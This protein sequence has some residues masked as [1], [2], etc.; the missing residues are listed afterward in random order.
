MN[1]STTKGAK[2]PEKHAA[3]LP[4]ARVM[5][6]VKDPS[7]IELCASQED[8]AFKVG[9]AEDGDEAMSCYPLVIIEP[10]SAAQARQIVKAAPFLQLSE[11]EKV[12]RL[13]A[14][15][16]GEFDDGVGQARAVLAAVGMGGGK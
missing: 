2:S 1:K 13:A 15:F 9:I 10:D 4:R 8:A 11:G 6:A 7:G 5:W 3:K 16:A 12:E 14:L